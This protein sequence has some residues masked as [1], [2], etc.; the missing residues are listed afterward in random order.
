MAWP[1]ADEE[2]A[3]ALGRCEAPVAARK[4]RRTSDGDSEDEPEA[5]PSRKRTRGD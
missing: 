2:T 4:K 1:H 3:Q 5:G